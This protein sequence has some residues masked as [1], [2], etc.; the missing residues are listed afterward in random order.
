[1]VCDK[2]EELRAMRSLVIPYTENRKKTKVFKEG[3]FVL[4]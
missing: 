4:L 3:E 1:M 2:A